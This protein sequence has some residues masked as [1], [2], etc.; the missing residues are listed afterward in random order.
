[1]TRPPDLRRKLDAAHAD[2]RLVRI[3]RRLRHSDPIS[4]FVVSVGRKW[5]L[6]AVTMDG[7][8]PDGWAAVRVKD[9]HRVRRDRSFEGA[10]ARTLPDW[11][12]QQ[13]GKV[14][15]DTT[16]A[17]LRT[18]AATA[19]LIGIEKERERRALWIGKLLR[20]ERGWVRLHEVGVDASWYRRRWYRVRAITKATVENHYLRGLIAVAGS[21]NSR[22]T[23]G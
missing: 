4:G 19:P 8:F 15:L 23:Q 22:Q 14:D 17:M 5:V 3:E 10:F 13:P 7:G 16:K 1:M 6:V 18:L 9:I 20:I 12:P 11:P 2:Q 21:P